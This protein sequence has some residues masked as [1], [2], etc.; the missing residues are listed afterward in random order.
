MEGGGSPKEAFPRMRSKRCLQPPPLGP[1]TMTALMLRH[2]CKQ[3]PLREGF[4]GLRQCGG[5]GRVKS[6]NES[7]QPRVS[8]AC[9]S[10]LWF[11]GQ[12]LEL[13]APREGCLNFSF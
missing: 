10:L 12:F 2:P 1:L 3:M 5:R 6:K 7:L 8:T 4:V 13:S 11:S 9:L